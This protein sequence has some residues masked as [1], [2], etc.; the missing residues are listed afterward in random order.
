MRAIM[1][2]LSVFRCTK[3]V[4]ESLSSFNC[5]RYFDETLRLYVLLLRTIENFILMR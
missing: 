5:I 1:A 2:K 4:I 3:L